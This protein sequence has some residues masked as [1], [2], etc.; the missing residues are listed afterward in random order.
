MGALLIDPAPCHPLFIGAGSVRVRQ[1]ERKSEKN[2]VDLL[3]ELNEDNKGNKALLEGQVKALNTVASNL[4]AGFNRIATLLAASANDT[5][6][7]QAVQS[8]AGTKTETGGVAFNPFTASVSALGGDMLRVTFPKNAEL[9]ADAK[10]KMYQCKF[11]HLKDGKLDAKQFR[12]SKMAAADTERTF[13]CT[14]P[15]WG[16]G[17]KMPDEATFSTNLQVLENGRMMPEPEG[18]Q[19]I[20]W[21]PQ[22]PA[23]KF[24]NVPVQFKGPHSKAKAFSVDL[25]V[26][27]DY[28]EAGYKDVVFSYSTSSAFSKIVTGVK[29]TGDEAQS[30]RKMAFSVTHPKAAKKE[31][32]YYIDVKITSKKY[33]LNSQQRFLINFKYQAGLG[34]GG[35][36]DLLSAAQV[37]SLKGKI[38][39]KDLE[40]EYKLCYA[41]KVHGFDT[42]I[43]HARCNGDHD[44]LHVQQRADNKRIFGGWFGGKTFS[45]GTYN[46]H[47]PNGN[48]IR[49]TRSGTAWMFRISP[50][51]TAKVEYAEKYRSNYYVATHITYQ[52]SWGGGNDYMCRND[53]YNYANM[54]HDYNTPH[55]YGGSASRTWLHGSYH[56]P[57]CKNDL[58]EIYHTE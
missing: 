30:L 50:S 6:R 56:Q 9:I 15:A 46:H 24:Y 21:T 22:T 36:D 40:R 28:G 16:E 4:N 45:L 29:F 20:K 25:E 23:F 18:G 39:G 7:F 54:D 41:S 14:V 51:A 1:V 31:T 42:K 38:A 52:F 57:T 2:V 10:V 37:A 32:Q 48:Y 58:I 55:N 47:G 34:P 8:G 3:T 5:K 19:V 43:F 35:K 11:T 49:G 26:L 17:G 27:Y 12:L 53:G 33:K 13:A 44:L